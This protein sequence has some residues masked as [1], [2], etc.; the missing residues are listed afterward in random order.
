MT[1]KGASV[2]LGLTLSI[3][4]VTSCGDQASRAGEA[5]D[6]GHYTVA[7]ASSSRRLLVCLP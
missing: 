6:D 5:A 3:P 7:Y 2:G 4:I 1:A